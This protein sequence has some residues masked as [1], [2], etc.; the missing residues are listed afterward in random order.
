MRPVFAQKI[1]INTAY[2]VEHI[3]WIIN[4]IKVRDKP[5]VKHIFFCGYMFRIEAI[6]HRALRENT[7]GIKRLLHW[8]THKMYVYP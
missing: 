4:S 7:A 8:S 6:H 3:P 2:L 1:L 5:S